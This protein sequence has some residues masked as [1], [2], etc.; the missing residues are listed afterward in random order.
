MKTLTEELELLKKNN[1][2]EKIR[3]EIFKSFYAR[4]TSS[5]S[6]GIPLGPLGIEYDKSELEQMDEIFNYIKNGLNPNLNDG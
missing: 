6:Q 2:D 3:L 1:N 5:E 4:K